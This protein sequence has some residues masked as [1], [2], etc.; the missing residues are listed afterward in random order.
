MSS[1]RVRVVITSDRFYNTGTAVEQSVA[2]RFPDLTVDVSTALAP[3]DE[4][5]IAVAQGADAI[6]TASIDAVPRRVIEALPDLR[7]I[8]RYAVGYDNIDLQ[9]AHEHGI[10][11]TH[12]PGYCT[13]EVADHA[14]S[15]ILA[16]NRRLFPSDQRLREGRWVGH[17]LETAY[18]TG[19][20]IWPMSSRT[21][22]VIGFGRI[23]QAV[24][25]R[26][27]PFGCA[28]VA[29][30]PAHD[31]EWVRSHGIEPVSLEEL[32]ASSDIV[33]I[34]CPLTP[35]THHLIGAAQLRTMRQGAMLVNTA[36]GPIVDG[37]ALA[38]ALAE[39]HLGAAAL[40]VMEHE[41]VG[42]DDP[43][44]R[45]PNLIVT[46]HSAYYSERSMEVLRRETYV[47][48]LSV[49]A[50]GPGRTVVNPPPPLS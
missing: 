25:A 27:R 46:P 50:G 49:L 41:P 24:V 8:G 29:A 19:G 34:H 39:G 9:A 15:L 18:V 1:H 28:I 6:V 31:P 30:D 4:T 3:D 5:M 42:P 35:D 37:D 22:G 14:L 33:T 10:V 40:D 7:V 44:L 17:N 21:V 47:D 43:L 16:L 2:E 13:D 20:E 23:G 38:A 32:L 48:V 11:V 36:R 26:L 12:Y 45:A